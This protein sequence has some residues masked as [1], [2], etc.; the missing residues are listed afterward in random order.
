M[1][2]QSADFVPITPY[3]TTVLNIAI[4]Q[5]YD[6]VVNADQAVGNYWLRALPALGCSQNNN[7]NGIQAI[8]TYEGASFGDPTSTPYVPSDTNCEDEVGLF[9]IVQRDISSLSYGIFENVS[10]PATP[11]VRWTMNNASFF[12]N[13][14]EPTLLMVEDH[15]SSYPVDYNVVSLDGTSDTWVY[16]VLQS[17][18]AFAVNHPVSLS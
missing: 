17:A 16:F 11:I 3:N 9:P 13:F 2:V 18:G 15:N 5:R 7:Q 6:I 12:T 4:G 8:V 10:L 1:T 14:E